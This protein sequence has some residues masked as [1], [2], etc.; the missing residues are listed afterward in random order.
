MERYIPV[1]RPYF[2]KACCEY[3]E[4]VGKNLHFG[5]IKGDIAIW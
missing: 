5:P 2:V 1:N 4:Q 3:S